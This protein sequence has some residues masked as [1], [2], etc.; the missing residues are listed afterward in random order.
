M[1]TT[2]PKEQLSAR[3]PFFQIHYFA[4]AASFTRKQSE[5]LP[6]PLPLADLFPL[7][8]AKYPGIT[9]RVLKSCSVSVGL[10]YVDVPEENGENGEESGVV[11]MIQAGDEV[12]IIPPVSS[13]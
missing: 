3:Q 6:A 10:D 5:S 7:L 1:T 4:S 2:P 13:G 9:Q 8:E 11:V 12:G